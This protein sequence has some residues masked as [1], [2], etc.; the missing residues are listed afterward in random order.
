MKMIIILMQIAME[1]QTKSRTTGSVVT[2]VSLFYW[3]K[4]KVPKWLI[5][6]KQ[7]IKTE[8][9][10]FAVPHTTGNNHNIDAVV[11]C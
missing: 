10:E 4:K 8:D 1:R 9:M 6:L 11:S 7:L 5:T 2:G 3:L